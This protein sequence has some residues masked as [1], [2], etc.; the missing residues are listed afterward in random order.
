MEPLKKEDRETSV[1][2]KSREAGTKKSHDVS[3]AE[4]TPHSS[5][6]E[7]SLFSS[8]ALVSSAATTTLAFK[9]KRKEKK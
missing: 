4:K 2:K 9:K 5:Q 3:D 6:W 8:S 7:F 1:H